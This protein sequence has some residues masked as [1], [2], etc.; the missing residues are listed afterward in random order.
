MTGTVEFVLLGDMDG[1]GDVDEMDVP[2]FMQ[3][4]VDPAAYDTAQPNIDADFVGDFDGNGLLDV[5]DL[6]AFSAAV[7]NAATASGEASAVPEP[8][9]GVLLGLALA[10]LAC[11]T[12]RRRQH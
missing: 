9:T 10:G 4:L 6:G 7:I 12:Y 11:G 3:A 8:V 5:G 1:D 2:L